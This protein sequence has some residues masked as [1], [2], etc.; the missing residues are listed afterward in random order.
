MSIFLLLGEIVKSGWKSERKG[1]FRNGLNSGGRNG[2][3]LPL[4][5]T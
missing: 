5:T 4:I 2:P 3:P 1:K